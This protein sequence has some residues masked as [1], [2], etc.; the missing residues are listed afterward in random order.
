MFTKVVGD[1]FG[2]DESAK[3]VPSLVEDARPAQG[4]GLKRFHFLGV[5]EGHGG[6]GGVPIDIGIH[7]LDVLIRPRSRYGRRGGSDGNVRVA[8]SH[9]SPTKHEKSTGNVIIG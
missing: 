7:E 6:L 4:N 5:Y 1:D 2:R 8:Q 9:F 3:I